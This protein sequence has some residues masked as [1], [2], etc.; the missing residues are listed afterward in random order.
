M[1]TFGF[2]R[3]E[4]P[5]HPDIHELNQQFAKILA[6]A[7][8]KLDRDDRKKWRPELPTNSY[9][10]SG[11]MIP[12]VFTK[13]RLVATHDKNEKVGTFALMVA[14]PSKYSKVLK[15]LLDNSI[16]EK[17]ITNLIPFAL[18][19]ENPDGFISSPHIKPDLWKL[20]ATSRFPM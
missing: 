5:D 16:M 7:W 17:K 14:T 20:I 4:H 18:N 10:T 6:D 11:L 19:R 13:E 2:L 12:L 8:R 15:V 1:Y 9:D 3:E